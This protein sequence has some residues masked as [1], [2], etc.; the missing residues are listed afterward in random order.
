[1]KRLLPFLGL[2]VFGLTNAS[3]QSTS[4]PL[5]KLIGVWNCS[6]SFE[7]EASVT[8]LVHET[9]FTAS[10]MQSVTGTVMWFDN[11]SRV[12]ATFEFMNEVRLEDDTL[13]VDIVSS[14][15]GDPS[16]L[17]H[18]SNNSSA[19]TQ[20]ENSVAA[21]IDR[22]SQSVFDIVELNNDRFVTLRQDDGAFNVC[23]RKG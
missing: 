21:N 11:G 5:S 9:E 4:A 7:D 8:R 22:D 12:R 3:A 2:A 16:Y 17:G 20:F 13:V 10:G 6:T 14:S 23:V 15:V 18:P 1:M 19:I